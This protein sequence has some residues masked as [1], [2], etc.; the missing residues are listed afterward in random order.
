MKTF[1]DHSSYTIV[2]HRKNNPVVTG[3]QLILHLSALLSQKLLKNV[4]SYSHIIRPINQKCQYTIR[5]ILNLLKLSSLFWDQTALYMNPLKPGKLLGSV[6]TALT[7]FFQYPNIIWC[8]F[9]YES[10]SGSLNLLC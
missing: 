9:I 8:I 3:L 7:E 4:L 1:E 2:S 5:W 6:V 10:C